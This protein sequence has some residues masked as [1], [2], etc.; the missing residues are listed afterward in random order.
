MASA[1]SE[2]A[3]AAL[4]G[5]ARTHAREANDAATAAWLCAIPCAALAALAIL[6]LGP[7]LGRL[8]IPAD[9]PFTF[10]AGAVPV[11]HPEPTET[12]RYVLAVC[13]PLLGVLAIALAPRWLTRVPAQWVAPTVVGTQLALAGLV[14]AAIANQYRLRFG[15]LYANGL[16]IE[17]TT[18]YFTPATLLVAALLAAAVVGLLRSRLRPRAAALVLAESRTRRAAAAGVAL[19]ATAIWM[20][21]AVHSDRELGNALVDLRQHL[22]FPFD[23]TFAVLNGRTPLVNFTPMYGAL[24][25]VAI[26]AA[27]ARLRQDGAHVLARRLHAQRPRAAGRLWRAAARGRQRDGGAAVVPAGARHEPLPG[28]RDAAR[29]RVG[30]DLLGTLPMRYA[31]PLLLAWLT[32]R[33]LERARDDLAGAWLL[34]AAAGLVLLNNVDFGL[35]ALG[36]TV[37]RA[38]VGGTATGALRTA[39][40]AA[41]RGGH[42]RWPADRA[43]A[44]V[45]ADARARRLA[46]AARAADRGAPAHMRSGGYNMI[47]HPERARRATCSCT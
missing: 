45:A 38:A 11:S 12:A 24:W 29:P 28:R 9:P 4:R 22:A 31:G 41:A 5:N 17:R 44:R 19:L 6:V 8:L 16:V 46:A 27:D 13:A 33:R 39:G 23:E 14:V 15:D 35:P 10:L 7:P 47:P 3:V 42:H 1:A 34:F 18:R 2:A 26:F 30:G 40:A 43:H 36:A 32:A 21:H 25:P 37:A 20:L